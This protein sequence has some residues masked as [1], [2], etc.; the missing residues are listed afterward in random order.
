ME[1]ASRFA[2]IPEGSCWGP[3]LLALVLAHDVL[4]RIRD[5]VVPRLI[6]EAWKADPGLQSPERAALS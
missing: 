2:G 3:V 4:P 5:H 1:Q 6:I